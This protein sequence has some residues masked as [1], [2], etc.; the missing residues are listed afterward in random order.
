MEAKPG[1]VSRPIPIIIRGSI[2]GWRLMKLLKTEAPLLPFFQDSHT[3]D[4]L[5]L[6]IQTEADEY[7]RS[8]GLEALNSGAYVWS[9]GAESA[10]KG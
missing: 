6:T 3:Q 8:L 9:M 5:R 10:K 7:W 4:L 1:D 2:V